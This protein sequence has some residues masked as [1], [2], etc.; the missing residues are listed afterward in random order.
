MRLKEERCFRV[1][2]LLL[3][4]LLIGGCCFRLLFSAVV[5]AFSNV[6]GVIFPAACVHLAQMDPDPLHMMVAASEQVRAGVASSSSADAA[7]P[8]T[9]ATAL[10]GTVRSYNGSKALGA[11]K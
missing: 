9:R 8:G 7:E 6:R 4:L 11:W 2:V 1:S 10:S 3:L 5:D